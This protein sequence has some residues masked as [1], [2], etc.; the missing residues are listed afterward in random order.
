MQN[1]QHD[2]VIVG[3]GAGGVA[4]AASLLK[5]RANLNI[6]LI[7]PAKEHSYQPGWTLVGG[8]VF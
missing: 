6:A 5:R 7:D 3:A 8:G 2:V 1:F 4:V